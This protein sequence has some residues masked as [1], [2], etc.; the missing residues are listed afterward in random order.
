MPWPAGRIVLATP[1]T[2]TTPG[3]Q[4]RRLVVFC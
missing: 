1:L 3:D 4:L 2:A